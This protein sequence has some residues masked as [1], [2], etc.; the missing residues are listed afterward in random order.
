MTD[1][2]LLHN[3]KGRSDHDEL[4]DHDVSSATAVKGSS[5]LSSS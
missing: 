2:G 4:P 1:P 3:M 5:T